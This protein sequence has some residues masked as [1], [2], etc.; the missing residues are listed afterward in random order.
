MESFF[1]L[2]IE[3]VHSSDFIIIFNVYNA[4]IA[5]E[6]IQT[7]DIGRVAEPGNH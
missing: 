4:S 7:M 1:E 3:N 5:G 2:L 6:Y